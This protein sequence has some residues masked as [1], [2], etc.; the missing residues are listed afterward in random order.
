MEG[1]VYFGVT[2]STF[3]L[4][5]DL[6]LNH[7]FLY[8]EWNEKEVFPNKLWARYGEVKEV[9]GGTMNSIGIPLIDTDSYSLKTV[10]HVW[11]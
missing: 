4:Y 11:I 7:F 9:V 1:K 2:L 5:L 6:V 3:I 8:T 10:L